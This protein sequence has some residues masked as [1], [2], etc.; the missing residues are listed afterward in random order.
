MSRVVRKRVLEG[1]S[2]ILGSLL[3]LFFIWYAYFVLRRAALSSAIFASLFFGSGLLAG[4]MLL[5]LKHDNVRWFTVDP[6]HLSKNQ[7]LILAVGAAIFAIC[8]V[9]L[10]VSQEVSIFV[11]QT[12]KE[13]VLYFLIKATFVVGALYATWQSVLRFKHGKN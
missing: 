7:N 6:T 10:A 13:D 8:F 2:L 11:Q 12:V 3:A 4:P 1:V 5:T 9:W